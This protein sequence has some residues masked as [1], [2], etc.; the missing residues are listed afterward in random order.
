[1]S[2]YVPTVTGIDHSSPTNSDFYWWQACAEDSFPSTSA[3]YDF[4]QESHHSLE[5]SFQADAAAQCVECGHLFALRPDVQTLL[6]RQVQ[7]KIYL[8]MWKEKEKKRGSLPKQVSSD[9]H[10]S[11]SGKLLDSTADKHDSEAAPRYWSSKGKPMEP[12]GQ[13]QASYPQTREDHLE[14][15]HIQLFW[16]LPTLHSE[17]LSPADHVL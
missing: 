15:N 5:A 6:E 16:G 2:N 9:S 8:M 3:Q 14:Q 7:K 17:F 12:H 1:L 11:S 10:L 4:D 13:Q